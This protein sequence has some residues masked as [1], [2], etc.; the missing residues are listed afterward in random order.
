MKISS[1]TTG[2][3]FFFRSF[4][5]RQGTFRY[6][7]L[8]GPADRSEAS[9]QEAVETDLAAERLMQKTEDFRKLIPIYSEQRRVR[10]LVSAANAKEKSENCGFCCC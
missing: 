7:R 6:L 3:S 4:R 2:A 8:G 10:P 9:R 1:I 5:Q